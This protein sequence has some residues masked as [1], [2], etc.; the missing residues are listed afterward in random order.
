MSAADIEHD[1]AATPLRGEAL[2]RRTD[3]RSWSVQ[4]EPVVRDTIDIPADGDLGLDVLDDL[5][6]FGLTELARYPLP[7]VAIA[8]GPGDGVELE[9]VAFISLLV[10]APCRAALPADGARRRRVSPA[11]SHYRRCLEGAARL[12]TVWLFAALS[13]IVGCDSDGQ[14]EA[15]ARL[16]RGGSGRAARGS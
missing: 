6:R 12:C 15:A 10:G 7:A 2:L 3:G 5:I 8:I 14:A 9:P 4:L 13:L 11:N 16:D 1:P